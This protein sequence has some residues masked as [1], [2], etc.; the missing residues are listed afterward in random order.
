MRL[1]AARTAEIVDFVTRLATQVVEDAG[2]AQANVDPDD[3]L[4][5]G[6]ALGGRAESFVTGDKALQELGAIEGL[7]ILSRR[8]L[9]V[10]LHEGEDDT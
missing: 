6:E 2:P 4:V 8:Q 7:R 1:P 10:A 9:W 3:A 5:L